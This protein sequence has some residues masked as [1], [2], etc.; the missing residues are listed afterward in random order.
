MRGLVHNSLL[1]YRAGAVH[2]WTEIT[3]A[4]FGQLLSHAGYTLAN[5]PVTLALTP[6]E[7]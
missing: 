7:G 2:V 3:T 4:A 6:P 5:C 1:S